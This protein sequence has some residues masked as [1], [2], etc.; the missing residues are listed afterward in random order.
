M[1]LFPI[2]P[3]RRQS[4]WHKHAQLRVINSSIFILKC[5][6]LSSLFYPSPWNIIGISSKR[7]R[8]VKKKE[9]QIF[10]SSFDHNRHLLKN[11]MVVNLVITFTSINVAVIL[12]GGDW[13]RVGGLL[14]CLIVRVCDRIRGCEQ[15]PEDDSHCGRKLSGTDYPGPRHFRFAAAAVKRGVA[16]RGVRH[17]TARYTAWLVRSPPGY[18]TNSS[19][20]VTLTGVLIALVSPLGRHTAQIRTPTTGTIRDKTVRRTNRVSAKVHRCFSAV[21]AALRLKR[22]P[23][24]HGVETQFTS[25]HRTPRLSEFTITIEPVR[26]GSFDRSNRSNVGGCSL[27]NDHIF[28]IRFY[29][30]TGARAY[31]RCKRRTIERID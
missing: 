15:Y 27:V 1:L 28:Q 6:C 4:A 8:N 30:V 2:L 10:Y 16:W 12:G 14:V 20:L 18:F 13:G 25:S 19:I 21:F 7:K 9:S 26:S 31:T 17:G 29:P 24:V 3:T 11:I 5:K 22:G 23:V